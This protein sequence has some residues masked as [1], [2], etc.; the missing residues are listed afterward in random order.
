MFPCRVFHW[1]DDFVLSC[2]PHSSGWDLSDMGEWRRVRAHAWLEAL[3]L[4]F[5]T[6]FLSVWFVYSATS[7]GARSQ[8]FPSRSQ[9]F[10]SDPMLA[11]DECVQV[12]PR[13]ADWVSISSA[14][15]SLIFK[16]QGEVEVHIVRDLISK[17]GFIIT[18]LI[19][20]LQSIF[21]AV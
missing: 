14:K 16:L 20:G 3:L 11:D 4:I 21:P 2:L 18:K 6:V 19:S 1:D 10:H 15:P 13:I 7:M 5:W 12:I 8:N 9:Q 17:W